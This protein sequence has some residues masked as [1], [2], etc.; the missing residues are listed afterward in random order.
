MTAPARP[1]E[2]EPILPPETA[3]DAEP[4][5]DADLLD[6]LADDGEVEET[7][8]P[9]R[10]APSNDDEADWSMRKLAV[11]EAELA[12]IRARRD[13]YV[14]RI[15]RWATREIQASGVE[16]RIARWRALLEDYALRRREED[17]A[18]TIWLPSGK[19]ATTSS[20]PAAEVADD[21][22]FVAWLR[23]TY[24]D[25]AEKLDAAVKVTAKPLIS[26]VKSELRVVERTR[27][28]VPIATPACGHEPIRLPEVE[29]EGSDRKLAE[30]AA[31]EVVCP[32]CYDPIDGEGVVAVVG[33]DRDD[34]TELVVV[35]TATGD[36]VPGLSVRP[37]KVTPRVSIGETR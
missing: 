21:E 10:W 6:A 29:V 30:M 37:A 23:D 11:A 36:V 5:T 7:A 18:A 19:V 8:A 32:A 1:I 25:D 3:L 16:K 34:V 17:G 26:A 24:D 31:S 22:T 15:D 14:E 20:K 35:S 28:V 9:L 2:D 27:A 4:F 33:V 12:E 13:A